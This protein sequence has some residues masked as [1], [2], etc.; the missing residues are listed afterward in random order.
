VEDLPCPCL[1]GRDYPRSAHGAGGVGA[2]GRGSRGI[3][4]T[5][6]R[7]GRALRAT[8]RMDNPACRRTWTSCRFIWSYTLDPPR[9]DGGGGTDVTV[10]MGRHLPHSSWCT[11]NLA[12]WRHKNFANRQ[13][14]SRRIPRNV[15][16]S[17]P[18]PW[19][20]CVRIDQNVFIGLNE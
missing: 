1:E 18:E 4:S 2:E 15:L 16:A 9:V 3:R 13:G 10:L 19:W 11:D 6:S 8:G 12:K 14:Q 20:E 5:L 7:L 17:G